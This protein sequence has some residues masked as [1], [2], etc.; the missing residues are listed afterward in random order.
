M[1][2]SQIVLYSVHKH[3]QR[4]KLLFWSK[5]YGICHEGCQK[6]SFNDEYDNVNSNVT[7]H[8]FFK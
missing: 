6:Q 1:Y 2:V 3:I 7:K 5:T 8:V 4:N